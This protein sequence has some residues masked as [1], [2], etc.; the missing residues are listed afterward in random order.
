M[1]FY[2]REKTLLINVPVANLSLVEHP[3]PFG[4]DESG[5]LESE[6]PATGSPST[7]LG[8][9]KIVHCKPPYL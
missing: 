1:V 6:A 3:I 8:S 9:H 5:S 7:D 4:L 2:P